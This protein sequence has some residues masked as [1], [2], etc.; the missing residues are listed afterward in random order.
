LPVSDQLHDFGNVGCKHGK[1]P[2]NKDHHKAPAQHR[3]TV[4]VTVTVK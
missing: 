3:R 1:T 2:K 4:D